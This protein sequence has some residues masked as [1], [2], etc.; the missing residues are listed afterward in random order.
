MR[1]A[2]VPL[3]YSY[4]NRL[5][6]E[7]SVKNSQ[8]THAAAECLI[9]CAFYSALIVGAL[10]G[11]SKE[12][13]LSPDFYLTFDKEYFTSASIHPEVL[14]VMRGSYKEKQPPEIKGKGYVVLSLEAALWAFYTT[15]N[16]VDGLIKVVNLGDD[17]DTTG[18][19][20]GQLAGAYYGVLAI[21]E[22]WRNMLSWIDLIEVFAEEIY[23]FSQVQGQKRETSQ[24]YKDIQTCFQLL[25]NGYKSIFT[26]TE[27]GPKMFKSTK[28]A[29]EA[30]ESLKLEYETKAP[31]CKEKKKLWDEIQIKIHPQRQVHLEQRLN[32]P[33]IPFGPF[34]KK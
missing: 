30:L 21:P 15:D 5:A 20:Y 23:A 10:Q 4:N 6:L 24:K 13:L 33:K 9:S 8:T 1:L 14:S 31:N 16:F 32:R 25:E 28:E 27:P 22:K 2:P 26:R 34:G 19:I 3:F 12:E 18:A 29:L 17:A 7:H 11:K